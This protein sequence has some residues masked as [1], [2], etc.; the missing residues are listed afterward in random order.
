MYPATKHCLAIVLP[1]CAHPTNANEI[2]VYDLSV[3]PSA[4]LTLNADEIKQRL[5]VATQDLPENVSRIALKTVHINK[6]PVLAPLSVLTPIEIERLKLNLDIC[7]A[8]AAQIIAAGD[9]TQKMHSV[10]GQSPKN[11]AAL[12]N[13]DLGLY[14]GGFFSSVD[15][16]AMIKIRNAPPEQ[17]ATLSVRYEDARI[18]EM[19]FRYRARNYPST[20]TSVEWEKWREFCIAQLIGATGD[21]NIT[22]NDYLHIIKNTLPQDEKQHVMIQ[23]LRDYARDKL[24]QL[25]VDSDTFLI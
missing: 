7:H 5:F 9:L 12:L 16:Q 22:L 24:R 17:L 4:L 19:L 23:A 15:K 8:H 14:N 10:F 25:D 6:C 21:A 11:V 1:L 13:V 18:E 2:I 20:L 3:E